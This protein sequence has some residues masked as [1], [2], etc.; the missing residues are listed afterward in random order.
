[1]RQSQQ[2]A[3]EWRHTKGTQGFS[4][5]LETKHTVALGQI[6]QLSSGAEDMVPGTKTLTR[7]KNRPPPHWMSKEVLRKLC[8]AMLSSSWICRSSHVFSGPVARMQLVVCWE[9]LRGFPLC[10]RAVLTLRLCFLDYRPWRAESAACPMWRSS[11][12][13]VARESLPLMQNKSKR[14]GRFSSFSKAALFE[15]TDTS[16]WCY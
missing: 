13:L 16:H 6:T 15:S 4:R 1:M 7:S 9:R 8:W 12:S 11:C 3:N 14:Q 5:S 2:E 10:T